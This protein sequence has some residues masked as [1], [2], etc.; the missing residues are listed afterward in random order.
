MVP[1]RPSQLLLPLKGGDPV[2]QPFWSDLLPLKGG[3]SRFYSLSGP[4]SSPKGGNSVPGEFLQG[5][6][7][8]GKLP[9]RTP[10]NTKFFPLGFFTWCHVILSHVLHGFYT[11]VT[12]FLHV[13]YRETILKCCLSGRVVLL[14]RTQRKKLCVFWGFLGI[15]PLYGGTLLKPPGIQLFP[16]KGKAGPFWTFSLSFS[17]FSPFL[18][19][20]F[21]FWFWCC[22]MNQ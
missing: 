22:H 3:E 9:E 20:S 15:V 19:L 16:W 18:S 21:S 13:V 7:L 5:S 1:P 8:R 4:T 10:K 6:P 14:S 2:L 11:R 17:F 12:W